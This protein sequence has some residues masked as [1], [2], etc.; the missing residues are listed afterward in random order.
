MFNDVANGVHYLEHDSL[1]IPYD[2]IPRLRAHAGYHDRYLTLYG[3]PISLANGPRST[4]AWYQYGRGSVEARQYTSA[5]PSHISVMSRTTGDAMHLPLD[6][7]ITHGAPRGR[8]DRNGGC[9]DLALRVEQV[10]PLVHV[11]GH[12]IITSLSCIAH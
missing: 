7:L 9:A 5:I 2:D 3:S 11:F 1:V 6:I 8:L 10:R 12:G 4:N